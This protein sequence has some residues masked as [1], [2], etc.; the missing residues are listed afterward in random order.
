MAIGE[1][2]ELTRNDILRLETRNTEDRLFRSC[3]DYIQLACP[4]PKRIKATYRFKLKRDMVTL[5]MDFENR[6]LDQQQ[7]PAPSPSS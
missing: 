1:W 3:N 5:R 7:S 2:L 4:F 6:D